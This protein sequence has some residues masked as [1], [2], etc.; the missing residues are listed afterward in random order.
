MLTNT[1]DE[2]LHRKFALLGV[3]PNPFFR[4]NTLHY[5]LA[6]PHRYRLD[7]YDL[8]GRKIRSLVNEK[9]PA[10]IYT[11]E[12]DGEN[13]ESGTYTYRIQIDDQSTTVK[14]FYRSRPTYAFSLTQMPA[15]ITDLRS[16]IV[17]I[18]K[19]CDHQPDLRTSVSK[20]N[21]LCVGMESPSFTF[22]PNVFSEKDKKTQRS[23]S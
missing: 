22:S 12:V 7:L 21:G 1:Q 14:W 8:G 13:L 20:I 2:V 4:K 17:Q 23:K 10:G 9:M 5:S 15:D 3:Y 16:L 6:T 11:L 19:N 18:R